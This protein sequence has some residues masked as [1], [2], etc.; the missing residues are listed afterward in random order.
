MYISDQIVDLELSIESSLSYKFLTT[1][2]KRW[3]MQTNLSVYGTISYANFTL[4]APSAVEQT[5]LSVKF[6]SF[7][8]AAISLA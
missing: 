3:A 1:K 7:I 5:V 8:T 6:H 2:L 4:A